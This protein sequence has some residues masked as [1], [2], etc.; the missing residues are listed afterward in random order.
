[1]SEPISTDA[2]S[3]LRELTR[4]DAG[5]YCGCIAHQIKAL[6][7]ALEQRDREL[8]ELCNELTPQE[9]ALLEY[10]GDNHGDTADAAWN[11]AA[12][13]FTDKLRAAID[14]L[15]NGSTQGQD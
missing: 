6:L 8:R 12:K 15:K 14:H 5:K 1:M 4:C 10:E 11:R 2:L 9:D 7:P 3:K 13:Y